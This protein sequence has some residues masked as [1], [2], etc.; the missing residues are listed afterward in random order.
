MVNLIREN[1]ANILVIVASSDGMLG[2]AAYTRQE[3]GNSAQIRYIFTEAHR[4]NEINVGSWPK[5][6][7]VGFI[8]LAVNNANRFMTIKLINKIKKLGHEILFVADE[9]DKDEWENV[10]KVCEI[11]LNKLTITPENRNE[12]GSSCEI[13]KRKFGDTIDEHTKELLDA[14]HQADQLN[15]E[16]KFGEYFNQCTKANP[17]DDSRKDYLVRHFSVH[18]APD[19]TILAWKK[20]Y[21]PIQLKTWEILETYQ[22]YSEEICIFDCSRGL[23]DVSDLFSKAYKIKPVVVLYGLGK[24]NQGVSIGT[25]RED[26]NILQILTEA[27]FCVSGMPKK[28]NFTIN[29]YGDLG[30]AIQAVQFKLNQE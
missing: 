16:T 17:R 27:N 1:V 20:E 3:V 7:K 22:E 6:S 11:D 29:N 23:C 4:V 9:H 28:A 12:F 26:V 8:D 2:A 24:H 13:L 14:G 15:F 10:F 18:D 21:L 30:Y 19:E 5:N 25:Y